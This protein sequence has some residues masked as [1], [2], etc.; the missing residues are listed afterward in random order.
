MVTLPAELE[1]RSLRI[2]LSVRAA[3]VVDSP[4]HYSAGCGY[5]DAGCVD[6]SALCGRSYYVGE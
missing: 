3:V 2:L 5:C 4:V 6:R 1:A